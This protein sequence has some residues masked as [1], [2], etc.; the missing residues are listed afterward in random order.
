MRLGNTAFFY[1]LLVVLISAFSVRGFGNAYSSCPQRLFLFRGKYSNSLKASNA[2]DF[3]T[4]D[5]SEPITK[6]DRRKSRISHVST[7]RAKN[8]ASINA[9]DDGNEIVLDLE[10]D[11]SVEG[12][13]LMVAV[14]GETGS[15]KSLLVSKVAELVTG[16]K[17]SPSLLHVSG[18]KFAGPTAS[19]EMGT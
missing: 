11:M 7:I 6:S 18:N 19:V 17:M 14:T 9:D 8:L 13:N 4:S 16:G 1:S 15:G 2:D 5:H 10:H 3:T 12:S